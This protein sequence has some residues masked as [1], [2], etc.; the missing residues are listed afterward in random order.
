M[1]LFRRWLIVGLASIF[2]LVLKA[3]EGMWMPRQRETSGRHDSR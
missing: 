3:D 1:R 2:S